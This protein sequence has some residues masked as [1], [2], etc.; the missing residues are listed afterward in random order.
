[1][2]EPFAQFHSPLGKDVRMTGF[3]GEEGLSQLFRFEVELVSENKSIGFKK[4][5]GKAGTVVLDLGE[6]KSRHLSGVVTRFAQIGRD[7]R[8]SF[9]RAEL[10]PW[11][12]LLEL[13][14]DQRIFQNKTTP[15]ILEAVFS[16]L[17]FKDFRKSLKAVYAAREYCVQYGESTLAFVCRLMEEEGIFY[18]FEHEDGK[19]TLVLGDDSD[20]HKK[21][22]GSGK[23]PVG[24]HP[25]RQPITHCEFEEQVVTNG[26]SL[27]DYNFEVPSTDLFVQTGGGSPKLAWYEYPGVYAKR[28]EG[29]T[30]AKLRIESRE[31]PGSVLRGQS[32]SRLLVSGHKFTLE[33]HERSDLNQDYVVQFVRHHCTVNTASYQNDFV[34]FP[35]K[36]P[37][38]PPIVTPKACI[39]GAQTAL[40]VGKSG[41]EIWTDKYG[42]VK[43]QFH[44]DRKGKKDEKSS[45]WIRVAQGWAGKGYGA[46]FIPRIG[47]E[48]VVTFLDGNPDR[49]LITGV[50]YNAQQ[51]VP[52]EL[53]SNQTQSGVKTK[54]SK[55]GS[56]FNELRFEDK[57]DSEEIFLHAQKDFN[58]VVLGKRTA[59]VDKD[60]ETKIKE[61]QKL[62]VE[63]DQKTTIKGKR[64]TEIKE[65]DDEYTV[66]KGNQKLTVKDG[67][68]EITI[69]DARKLTVKGEEKRTNKK[70]FKHA[71]ED[72]YTLKVKK[73]LTIEVN[74]DIKIKGKGKLTIEAASAIQIKSDQDVEVKGLNVKTEAQ[75]DV[76]LKA[77]A[78]F[79]A[80]GAMVKVKASATG[81]VDGGGMLTLK[82]GMVKIN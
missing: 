55:D 32:S 13:T 14:A 25:D 78:N 60:D 56:G 15:E 24:L 10:R 76:A 64:E 26:Y 43:V 31:H 74:G 7:A 46:I 29:D 50:V 8:H 23:V 57:K 4:I 62:D 47:Q 41:E 65:G 82:G 34:A 70:A 77:S 12:S 36:L 21:G 75:A 2:A 67:S 30:R 51:T 11:L 16:D 72:E 17:G 27:S 79:K 39:A 49:P 71:A 5:L 20:A 38:R 9:Y 52:Y 48:V 69:G 22:P 37:F 73:D 19:H 40:V 54:S 53:P 35:A 81:E 45:I 42:R 1:M 28:D 63:G 59:E 66:K 68:Q 44:W 33:E 58:Q 80:E 3:T 18:F 6:G 61:N